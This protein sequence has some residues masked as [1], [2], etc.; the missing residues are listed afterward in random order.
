MHWVGYL[1]GER[2]PFGEEFFWRAL[3]IEYNF[4]SINFLRVGG[5]T[6]N[7]M[8]RQLR[9]RCS[10]DEGV[11]EDQEKDNENKSAIKRHLKG[12]QPVPR[13]SFRASALLLTGKG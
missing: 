1:F 12:C 5:E 11:P 7:G 4:L 9:L 6:G 10:S 13:T 3:S 8:L 2:R